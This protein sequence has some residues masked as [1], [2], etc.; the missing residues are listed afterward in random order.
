MTYNKRNI[1]MVMLISILCLAALLLDLSLPLG[2]AGGIPYA[3]IIGVAWS[4]QS[5]RIVLGSVLASTALIFIGYWFSPPAVSPNWVIF[6]NRFFALAVSLLLAIL[7]LR[8]I[9][10]AEERDYALREKEQL[11]GEFRHLRGLIPIC[12][13]CKQIRSSEGVWEPLESYL[14]QHSDADFSHGLC[15]SCSSE[16]YPEVFEQ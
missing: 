9:R 15:T 2:F 14:S 16:L 8:S 7:F 5:R 13:S 4:T 1:K 10:T 12:S 11:W 3:L 6:L